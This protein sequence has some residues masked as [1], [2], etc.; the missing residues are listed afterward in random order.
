[1]LAIAAEIVSVPS[2]P[3]DKH[4][5]NATTVRPAA[6]A[7]VATAYE[8]CSYF[9]CAKPSCNNIRVLTLEQ[10]ALDQRKPRID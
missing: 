8:R 3:T 1:L 7:T 5:K 9:S 2:A 4:M 6:T 10:Q